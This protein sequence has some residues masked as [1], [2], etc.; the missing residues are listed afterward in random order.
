MIMYLVAH[1]IRKL[2]RPTNLF[3]EEDNQTGKSIAQ[4]MQ[5][6]MDQVMPIMPT[7]HDLCAEIRRIVN[8]RHMPND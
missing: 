8:R 4:V 7:R 3:S 2:P 1:A 6:K 5:E